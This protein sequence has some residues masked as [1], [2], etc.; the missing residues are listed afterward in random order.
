MLLPWLSAGLVDWRIAEVAMRRR[1]FLAALGGV[2][3]APLRA[4][5]RSPGMPVI[6]YLCPEEPG[7][8]A[9]RVNAFRDGLAEAGYLE[10]RNVAIEF[11]WAKGEYDKLAVLASDLAARQV[12]VIVAVG[13]A[14]SALA[15][16]AATATIPIVFEMGGDP[17]A[18][19]VVPSL[20]RPDGNCTGVS[21]LNVEVGPKRLESLHE[22]VPPATAFGVVLNPASPTANSQSTA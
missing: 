7:A 15:A 9:S 5:A 10:G 18:L 8:F 14:P 11:C 13:G 17:V 20:S 22:V 16:K 4:Y 3:T 6:G 2:L 21:S 1:E 19:G 12:A